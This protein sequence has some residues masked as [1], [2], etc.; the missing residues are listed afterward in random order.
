MRAP[1]ALE[2]A[3][4]PLKPAAGFLAQVV[5]GYFRAGCV[6][7]AAALSFFAL[8][9]FLPILVLLLSLGG[10]VIELLGPQYGSSTELVERIVAVAGELLPAERDG[11]TQALRTLVSSRGAF[12]IFG[13]VVLF[14]SASMVFGAIETALN[15]VF[16]AQPKRRW[17]MRLLFPA[18]VCGVAL[19]LMAGRLVL[20]LLVHVI[21]APADSIWGRLETQLLIGD[22]VFVLIVAGGVVA[23]FRWVCAHPIPWLHAIAGALLFVALWRLARFLL[24]LYFTSLAKVSV[25]YGSLATLVV[26][27]VWVYYTSSTLLLSAVVVRVLGERRPK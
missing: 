12:G 21:D 8:A 15:A 27:F 17:R 9:S 6:Q 14:L 23:L 24:G 10:Y 5:R 20:S 3:A 2:K 26:V 11:L 1:P 18:L 4:R 25:L 19:L 22:I 13:G 16:G 7:H